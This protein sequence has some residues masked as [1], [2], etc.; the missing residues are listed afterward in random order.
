MD[1]LRLA[2]GV[3]AVSENRLVAICEVNGL[4]SVTVRDLA[5]GSISV[6]KAGD[7]AVPRNLLRDG[8]RGRRAAALAMASARQW[9][10]A[11]QREAAV[12]DVLADPAGNVARVAQVRGITARSLRRWVA[13]YRE[14]PSISALLD[15][16]WGVQRGSARLDSSVETV[17][18]KVVDDLYLAR[19]KA[20][21][22]VVHE[23]VERRC[24]REGLAVPSLNAVIR[25]I[26]SLDPWIVAKRQLGREE[27][28][29][30]V[31]PKPGSLE[32]EGPLAMVQIDHTLVDVHVVD[33]VHRKSIGR[34]WI[35]LAIDVASRC[36]LGFH[37]SL[38]APSTASVAACVAHSFRPKD[39]WLAQNGIEAQWPVWGLPH[40]LHADNAKEFKTEALTR[41]C[42]DWSIEMVWRPMGKPHYGGHV[43]RLIGTLMGRVHLLPGTTQSNPIARGRYRA[44]DA[45][46]LS[47][48]E[49]Q[50][51]IALEI[52]ERYHLNIHRAL[53]RAP[54]D[55]WRDWFARRGEVPAI[56]GDEQRFR[57]SFLPI[58]YR[59]LQRQGLYFMQIRYW[60]NVLPT[61]AA[62]GARMLLRYDPSD[63]SRLYALDDSGR[64]WPIPYADL[65][66]PA[67]TL[68]EAR[69]AMAARQKH[70]AGRR[71]EVRFFERAIKQ[72]AVVAEAAV[73][74]KSARRIQ[75]RRT[76][77]ARG[78]SSSAPATV[79][80][81]DWNKPVVDYGVE[82]WVEE[83]R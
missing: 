31:G 62:M 71:N 7:L 41:G 56:P 33:D 36:V 74:S 40:K 78:E 22:A 27:A 37:L 28:M 61:L 21:F 32:A 63:L 83:P 5:N 11:K 48:S 3:V 19:P 4:E 47:L 57:L 9:E 53:R 39:R 70:Q 29:R 43:E 13:T 26:R 42:A 45:A 80:T 10:R 65:R 81:V 30:R 18:R 79:D 25:R 17:I 75:Q 1:T 69:S 60:D 77:A 12:L 55:A 24:V 50:R 58:V 54:I 64:Y 35:T 82:I 49:L 34:P 68:S 23:E 73:K 6:V 8:A 66:H 59:K 46:Q 20:S 44:E 76:E 72:R 38:E 15:A 51:W 2:A 52:C 67:I 16:T 14:S